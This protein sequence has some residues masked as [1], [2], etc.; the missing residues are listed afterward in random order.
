MAILTL[1]YDDYPATVRLRLSP[2]SLD[3]FFAVHEAVDNG[4]WTDRASIIALCE[5]IAPLIES[6]T[7]DRPTDAAGVMADI[8]L[9]VSLAQHWDREVRQVPTPLPQRLSGG[10]PSVGRKTSRK[11]STAPS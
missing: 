3:E 8:G 7:F 6:W 5:A 9:A 4:K 10:V 11:N 1:E 2:V